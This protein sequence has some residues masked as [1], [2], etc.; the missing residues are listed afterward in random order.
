MI[1]RLLNLEVAKNGHNLVWYL[2]SSK[3]KKYT[4]ISPLPFLD[5][6]FTTKRG[7]GKVEVAYPELKYSISKMNKNHVFSE[8]KDRNE[9]AYKVELASP[10]IKN[11]IRQTM[12][13]K[14]NY[15]LLYEADVDFI[16]LVLKDLGI[17][18]YIDDEPIIPTPVTAEYVEEHLPDFAP[19][20][21]AFFDFETDDRLEKRRKSNFKGFAKSD[22]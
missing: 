14:P 16:D 18:E 22:T 20:L 7:V 4:K 15:L 10:R 19:V 5:Y 9:A 21:H 6:F 13:K 11:G 8:Y 1:S 3:G 17:S 2:M 12:E